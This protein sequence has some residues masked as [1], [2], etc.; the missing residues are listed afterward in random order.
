MGSSSFCSSLCT[1]GLDDDD[2]F[3]QSDF[4]GSGKETPGVSNGFHVNDDTLGVRIITQIVDQ[5]AP[6]HIE[7][8]ADGDEVAKPYIL[9]QTPI[10]DRGAQRAA[11]ADKA[12]ATAARDCG[13]KGCIQ[14]TYR[15]HDAQTVWSNDAHVT[16]AGMLHNLPFEFHTIG[17]GLFKAGGNNDGA[18]Y[19]KVGCFL[20]DDG[21][22]GSGGDHNDQI[23][24]FGYIRESGI[25]LDT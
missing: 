6:I 13:C 25:C 16:A 3:G 9:A 11:L 1:T 19:T 7:H 22:A 20:D 24:N 21:Y 4:A 23:H 8:R 5:I 12:N 17:S 18:F 15:A 2:R 10:E 14:T